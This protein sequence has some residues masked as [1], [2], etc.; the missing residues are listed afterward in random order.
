MAK[1]TIGVLLVNL[2]TP[3]SP[4]TG[5][6]RKYLK[7]FLM[8]GRVIDIPVVASD[9]RKKDIYNAVLE[10]DERISKSGKVLRILDKNKTNRLLKNF[11]NKGINSIAINLINGFKHTKHEREILYL[12]KKNRLQIYIM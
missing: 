11:F 4:S 1:N 9:N 2:G 5:D 6:V 8:D 7:E 3:D 12:A 10:V